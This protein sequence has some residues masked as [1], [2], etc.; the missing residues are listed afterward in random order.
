[1]DT[2]NKNTTNAYPNVSIE[3]LV[4]EQME[5]S[6]RHVFKP[7]YEKYSSKFSSISSTLT[8]TDCMHVDAIIPYSTISSNF[9]DN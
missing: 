6:M 8:V 2:K 3:P 9:N 5:E 1:M 7:Y 4:S